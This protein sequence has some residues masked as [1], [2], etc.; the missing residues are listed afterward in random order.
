MTNRLLL[1]IITTSF[2]FACSTRSEKEAKLERPNILQLVVDDMGYSD[3]KSYKGGSARPFIVHWP[4]KMKGIGNTFN[5]GVAHVIDILPTCVAL[6]ESEYLDLVNGLKTIPLSEKNMLPL[7]YN[8]TKAFHDTLYWEPERGKAI[9]TGDWNMSALPNGNWELFNLAE[10][11]IEMNH[12]T[13]QY[14]AKVA[15]M[16]Q[17]WKKWAYSVGLEID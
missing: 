8:E 15:T 2:L 9:R 3:F 6:S 7:L 12:L 11:H 5:R 16:G 13:A 1:L 14:P 10:D 4:E 17:A